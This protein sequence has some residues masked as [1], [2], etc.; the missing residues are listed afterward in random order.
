MKLIRKKIREMLDQPLKVGETYVSKMQT[1][2]KFTITEIVMK[3][4]KGKTHE[5]HQL[6]GIWEKS[7]HLGACPIGAERLLPVQVESG[8]VLDE[9][10]CPH[11]KKEVEL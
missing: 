8:R 2:E 1:A 5:I 7:P 4:E 11:C 6:M 3:K 10:I 9:C